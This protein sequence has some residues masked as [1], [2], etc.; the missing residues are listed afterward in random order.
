ML[1]LGL[2][3]AAWSEADAARTQ[4]EAQP[5]QIESERDPHL[6]NCKAVVGYQIEA[7]GGEIG[8]VE[9]LIVDGVSWAYGTVAMELARDALQY[10]PNYGPT[11]RPA[12]ERE[13]AVFEHYGRKG[14]W[15][16]VPAAAQA[17]VQKK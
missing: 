7:S 14:C 17:V 6:R 16:G 5:R 9:G 1:A 11:L 12:R 13:T 8:H 3:S 2:P 4:T 10:A 15:H